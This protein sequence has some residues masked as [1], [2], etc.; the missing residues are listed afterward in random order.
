MGGI[1]LNNMRR[2]FPNL[3]QRQFSVTKYLREFTRLS[4]Y[5]PEMLVTKKEK[6][7]KF[8]DD[9]NDHSRAH[10]TGFFHDDFSKIKTC[11]LTVERVKKEENERKY[12]RQGKKNHVQ[13][14]A[15]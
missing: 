1:Y 11:A 15:H 8:E 14:S 6:C 9:L 7:H 12:R 4:K 10:V 3:K 2:E 5:A 13:S